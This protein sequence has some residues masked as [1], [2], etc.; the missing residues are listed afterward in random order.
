M[1]AF[2]KLNL[3]SFQMMNSEPSQQTPKIPDELATLRIP[4]TRQQPHNNCVVAVQDLP[5]AS[6]DLSE[7]SSSISQAKLLSAL[8]SLAESNQLHSGTLGVQQQSGNNMVLAQQLTNAQ[9]IDALIASKN[10]NGH[11]TV[12][13]ASSA[14]TPGVDGLPVMRVQGNYAVGRTEDSSIAGLVTQDRLPLGTGTLLETQVMNPQISASHLHVDTSK[15]E[16]TDASVSNFINANK[17]LNRLLDNTKPHIPS[18]IAKAAEIAH[19]IP[20]PSVRTASTTRSGDMEDGTLDMTF[21]T[22]NRSGSPLTTLTRSS[23]SSMCTVTGALRSSSGHGE[24]SN[25]TLPAL[26]LENVNLPSNFQLNNNPILLS[27]MGGQNPVPQQRHFDASGQVLLGTQNAAVVEEPRLDALSQESQRLFQ[28]LPVSHCSVSNS[29]VSGINSLSGSVLDKPKRNILLSSNPSNV[30]TVNSTCFTELMNKNSCV[31]SHSRPQMTLSS[32]QGLITST[33]PLLHTVVT[34]SG[35]LSALNISG[36]SKPV[37][38]LQE[39][40]PRLKTQVADSRLTQQLADFVNRGPNSDIIYDVGTV[41]LPLEIPET[42]ISH[43]GDVLLSELHRSDETDLGL[44]ASL[45]GAAS[46][47]HSNANA[48]VAETALGTGIGADTAPLH[49]LPT[50]PPLQGLPSPPL[51]SFSL[52]NISSDFLVGSISGSKLSSS[53]GPF[54]ALLSNLATTSDFDQLLENSSM[55]IDINSLSETEVSLSTAPGTFAYSQEKPSN[56]KSSSQ[57][58]DLTFTSALKAATSKNDDD[59]KLHCDINPSVKT[60]EQRCELN[61]GVDIN[62]SFTSNSEQNVNQ[63][64]SSRPKKQDSNGCSKSSSGSREKR[65]EIFRKNELLVQ[66]V[67]C[68]KCRLCSFLSQ[69]KGEMV[70]HMKQL[71]SQYLSESEESETEESSAKKFKVHLPRRDSL[72][73]ENATEGN[74]PTVKGRFQSNY[75]QSSKFRVTNCGFETES[76]FKT[77]IKEEDDVGK[78]S[79][80]IKMEPLEDSIEKIKEPESRM[81]VPELESDQTMDDD[82]TN[83]SSATNDSGTLKPKRGSGKIGRPVYS[84]STGITKL[85]KS[86]SNVQAQDK[87]T[88]I[89]CDINSCGLRMKSESNIE[90]HRKCHQEAM[91]VCPECGEKFGMWPNLAVHLWRQHMIDMELHKCDKCNYKSYK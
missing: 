81:A 12:T 73:Q 64:L 55:C 16:T 50:A 88:G 45:T 21:S 70:K 23:G 38:S 2:D 25:K 6:L 33:D 59:L 52:P 72:Q 58:S 28:A 89:R 68:F 51:P 71:H 11:T 26:Q 79:I 19:L 31:E 78:Y 91:L 36:L 3:F 24:T 66:Q 22:S 62:T 7:I 47:L 15:L 46:D 76:L 43:T 74:L 29:T 60:T 48:L 61:S 56:K 14:S 13:P 37:M 39:N 63:G 84:K 8:T 86:N 65:K 67:A 87:V 85:K 27:A 49:V 5:S 35:S 9:I 34:S 54:P 80:F 17:L 42:R 82:D 57:S 44:N 10:S 20:N 53:Q 90:Y 41:N 69:D 30:R 83:D 1:A 32:K 75:T 40:T 77:M 18:H 4:V